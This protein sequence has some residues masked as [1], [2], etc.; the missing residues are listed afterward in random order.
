M[1]PIARETVVERRQTGIRWSSVLAGAIVAIALWI[2]L[3]A[4]GLG[5]GLAAIDVDDAGS[6]RPASV[7][8]GIWSLIAPIIALFVG[9]LITARS[10]QSFDR[11]IGVIHGLTMWAITTVLGVLAL[12]WVISALAGAVVSTGKAA[13]QGAGNVIGATAGAVDRGTLSSLGINADDVLAPINQRLRQAGKP[14]VTSEQLTEAGRDVMEQAVRQGR[15]DRNVLIERLDA[16]TDLDRQDATEVANAIDQRFSAARERVQQAGEQAG[17]KAKQAALTAA[18]KTGKVMLWASLWMLLSL[19][20]AIGGALVGS[21]WRRR[22]A[23]PYGGEPVRPAEPLV[24]EPG[25]ALR[26]PGPATV[27][28]E[29]PPPGAPPPGGSKIVPP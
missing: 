4:L 23:G 3:H 1:Q 25:P 7:G 11:G 12:V 8:T 6:L 22:R 18:D 9:G 14:E 19:A 15:L 24:R 17:A 27:V 29:P 5:I 10:S 28:R 20:A 26:E 13:V 16:N 2:L 21:A